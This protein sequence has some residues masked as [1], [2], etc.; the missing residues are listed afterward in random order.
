MKTVPYFVSVAASTAFLVGWLWFFLPDI[1][2]PQGLVGI[3]LAL[4]LRR[5]LYSG[6]MKYWDERR[7]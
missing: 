2:I 1:S 3:V 6:L 7:P 4:V 5:I